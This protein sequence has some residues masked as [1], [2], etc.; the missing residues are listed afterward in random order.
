[1]TNG[2]PP[3]PPNNQQYQQPQNYYQQPAQPTH[4][5]MEY[6]GFSRFVPG[7]VVALL[8]IVLVVVG[9]LFVGTATKVDVPES[10][11]YTSQIEAAKLSFD[12]NN[13]TT[14]SAPQQQVVNGWYA[15]DLLVIVA[16]GI[17]AN[18]KAAVATAAAQQ[19]VLDSNR[20][21]S[22]A[23]VVSLGVLLLAF[24]AYAMLKEWLE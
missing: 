19:K 20:L 4:Q 16:K 13:T 22:L 14:A 7:L 23:L 18:N 8:A 24:G 3:A 9:F 17:D 2:Q 5:A 12:T 6:A 21:L 10:S 1:M 11:N 15:N